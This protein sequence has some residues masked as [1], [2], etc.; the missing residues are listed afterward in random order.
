MADGPVEQDCVLRDEDGLAVLEACSGD[1]AYRLVRLDIGSAGGD[2]FVQRMPGVA[3]GG[4]V[5]SAAK[6][7][8]QHRIACNGPLQR[9]HG[10]GDLGVDIG[11]AL[12]LIDDDR[13]GIGN[14]GVPDRNA[15]AI[16]AGDA[17]EPGD[18]E[19][20]QQRSNAGKRF[21]RR[22]GAVRIGASGQERCVRY[23]HIS[24]LLS[25]VK[26]RSPASGSG[27]GYGRRHPS[28]PCRSRGP[29]GAGN[30]KVRPAAAAA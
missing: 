17:G 15:D 2:Q 29:A 13:P 19:V 26:D 23:R 22:A 11:Q 25:R 24:S 28:R 30:P 3:V 8:G 27:P 9:F 14:D 16:E 12:A 7:R 6:P 20:G 5:L 1:P 4:E 18:A 21:L 10:G